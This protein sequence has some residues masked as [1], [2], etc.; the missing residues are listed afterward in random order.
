[1]N[2]EKAIDRVKRIDSMLDNIRRFDEAGNCAKGDIELSH[3]TWTIKL[4]ALI[5]ADERA[6]MLERE[7]QRLTEE[8]AKLQPVIDMANA[9]LKGIHS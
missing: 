8:R 6:A 7:R 3:G 4:S 9:A 5:H 1:M 2:I